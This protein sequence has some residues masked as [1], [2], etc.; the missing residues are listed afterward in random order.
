M[1]KEEG[2]R[3]EKRFIVLLKL[4]KI[5]NVFFL[6]QDVFVSLSCNSFFFG[7]SVYAYKLSRKLNVTD[8]EPAPPDDSPK[9]FTFQAKYLWSETVSKRRKFILYTFTKV[10]FFTM[11]GIIFNVKNIF[12]IFY[13]WPP[14]S[15]FFIIYVTF[16]DCLWCHVCL[17]YMVVN[18]LSVMRLAYILLYI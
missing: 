15:F 16:F 10:F 1:S 3:S 7:I 12:Y 17:Q 4:I 8:F 9:P 13:L 14:S 6:V 2:G 11:S 18:V 5:F